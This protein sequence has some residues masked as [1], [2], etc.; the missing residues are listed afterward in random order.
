MLRHRLEGRAQDA[1]LDALEH[2]AV[3]HPAQAALDVR[4]RGARMAAPGRR[5]ERVPERRP[6]VDGDGAEPEIAERVVERGLHAADASTFGWTKSVA[7]S[8][9]QTRSFANA[10]ASLRNSAGSSLADGDLAQDR[11]ERLGAEV[12]LAL[13]VRVETEHERPRQRVLAGGA[14]LSHVGVAGRQRLE[15][16]RRARV[17]RLAR[18]N[19][20]AER[21]ASFLMK[22]S[23]RAQP[24]GRDEHLGGVAVERR[25]VGDHARRVLGHAR[26]LGVGVR[27][28][29][30]R[31]PGSRS[32]ARS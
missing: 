31:S 21:R 32:R 29:Q 16:L 11:A 22:A 15:A 25:V 8:V 4:E 6:R 28:G 27:A 10:V 7:F 2:H 9:P 1:L 23:R 13:V 20:L 19:G 24:F 3:V 14:D 18:G 26:E 12:L 30:R 17:V 5:H